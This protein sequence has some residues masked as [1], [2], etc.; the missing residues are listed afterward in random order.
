VRFQTLHHLTPDGVVGLKTWS[1]L[2]QIMSSRPAPPD[3]PS[4]PAWLTIARAELGIHETAL[5]GQHNLR[6]VEYH[7]TTTLKAST[8]ETPWCASFVNWVVIKAGFRGTNNALA[9]SWLEWGTTLE[10]PR[11]GAVTVIKRKGQTHDAATGSGTG[12]HVAFCIQ[13]TPGHIRL[14]GG[15]QGDQVKY[16]NF[17]LSAYD[18]RGYRWPS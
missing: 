11:E 18:I 6:I 5:P 2:G 17:L 14:L 4:A 12:F 8:D 10:Q 3:N 15:N 16:S 7:S 9:K 1:A 13:V